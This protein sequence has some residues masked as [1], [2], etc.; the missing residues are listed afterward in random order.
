MDP[1]SAVEDILGDVESWPTCILDIF[2]V[3]PNRLSVQN[4]AAFMYGNGVPVE[5]AVDCF[6]ACIGIDC[7]YV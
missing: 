6:V 4:V 1:L 2:V 7:Y 5:K 3:K